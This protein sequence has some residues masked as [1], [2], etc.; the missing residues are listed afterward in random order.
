[1]ETEKAGEKKRRLPRYEVPESFAAIGVFPPQREHRLKVKDIGIG[2]IRFDT[3]LDL[4]RESIFSLVFEVRNQKGEAVRIHTLASIL[5]FVSE[6]EPSWYTA[7]AQFL[8]LT[9][10]DKEILQEFLAT[11]KPK[12]SE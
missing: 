9:K 3:N 4:S 10:S 8:G 1:M 11:L 5:W 12:E 2:S 7:G 6:K